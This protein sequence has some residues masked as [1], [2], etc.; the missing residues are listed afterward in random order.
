M[1]R[2]LPVLVRHIKSLRSATDC[3]RLYTSY[4]HVLSQKVKPKC[5]FVFMKEY[6][7]NRGYLMKVWT[8]IL[9]YRHFKLSAMLILTYGDLVPI[10][11]KQSDKI[12][13]IFYAFWYIILNAII[14]I[15]EKILTRNVIQATCPLHKYFVI[16]DRY[17]GYLFDVYLSRRGTN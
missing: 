8:I 9:T 4:L 12:L 16:K 6:T 5:F 10:T 7:N 14:A 1:H 2:L 15:I 17:N 3:H 11:F 13:L